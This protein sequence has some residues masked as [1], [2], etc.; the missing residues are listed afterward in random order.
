MET[1]NNALAEIREGRMTITEAARSFDIPVSTLYG[2]VGKP[3]A[4]SPSE[5][6]AVGASGSNDSSLDLD[7]NVYG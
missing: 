6:T 5:R 3:L 7:I 1:M 2:R 4:D